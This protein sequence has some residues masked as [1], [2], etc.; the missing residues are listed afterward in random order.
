MLTKINNYDET[1]Y[2]KYKKL[3]IRDVA[4]IKKSD[5]PPE[6]CDKA[7]VIVDEFIRKTRDLDFEIMI[8]FD[9]ETGDILE[10]KIGGATTVEL[11]FDENTF[12][13]KHIASL[14][15]H[16]KDMYTPPSDMNFGI[17]LRK[18]EEYELIAGWDG[19]WILKG[20]LTDT[21]LNF[22]LKTNSSILFRRVLNH[23]SK[24]CFS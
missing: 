20:K 12:D 23:F 10:R 19:L 8:Y 15:N 2:E 24:R 21:K 3:E 16:T 4:S 14:H 7:F 11:E 6:F 13:E 18:W 22:E 5:L 17:F 1:D 9:Y